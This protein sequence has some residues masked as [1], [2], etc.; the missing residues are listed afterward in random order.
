MADSG[1]QLTGWDAATWRT[2]SGDPH[3]RST[4]VALVLLDSPPDWPRLHARV[5][6]LTRMVP[7]LRQRAI[8]GVFGVASPRLAGD[9]DFDLDLHL[10]RMRLA[11]D[12]SWAELMG[13]AR[14][15]SLTDF[16]HD[17]ALWEIVLVEGLQGGRAAL[18]LKLHHAIADGQATVLIG[19]NLVELTAEAD[20]AEAEAPEAPSVSDIGAPQVSVADIVD[21]VRRGFGA[22]E[23]VGEAMIA[24]ARGTL[25]DPVRTWGSLLGTVASVGRFAAVP[26]GPLSPVMIERGTTYHFAAFDLP[27]AAL[28][29]SARERGR[30]VNDAFMAAVG[31]G[32]ERYHVRRGTVVDDLRFNVPISLRGDPGDTSA[33]AANAVTI[34]RFTLP[35]AGLTVDERM[36]SA[37]QAVEQWRNEPALR[38][39][40]PLAEI[41]WLVPMP[42][43]A[44]AAFASDVT[45]SNV[46]G[47]PLPLFV[48]G[49]RIAGMYPL[50]ATIGAAVNVTMVTYD[51][52]A[53]VGI[54]GDDR[55]VP[56]LD[57]LVADMRSGFA[58]VIGEPV[59]PADPLSEP[60]PEDGTP[61]AR[62]IRA[63]GRSGQ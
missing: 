44:Q 49:A 25:T 7:V 59:G 62:A 33:Q 39:A 48:A 10:R 47:P 1:R 27:F 63:A 19:L 23:R 20:P 31:L 61:K 17:R 2:A 54:S 13:E 43:L 18:L 26:D 56:D 8:R 28:R 30:S 41:S 42:L 5:E 6:R 53:F 51:G 40:D 38:F 57:A 21:N 24:L 50:V 52:T 60:G 32:L 14:R 3:L 4:V 37:H 22:A 58:T 34:A 55:A 29:D 9:P 46:P 36:D 12:G 15:V 45:T 16:D 11:G 35:V